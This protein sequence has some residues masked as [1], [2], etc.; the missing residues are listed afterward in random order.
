[1]ALRFAI[2]VTSKRGAKG[3]ARPGAVPGKRNR[4]SPEPWAQDD[5][6]REICR[7]KRSIRSSEA[8]HRRWHTEVGRVGNYLQDSKLHS[9]SRGTLRY[10]SG[11]HVDGD[12]VM[13]IR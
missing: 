11:F 9:A 3:A 4:P 12:G 13:T 7:A 1:M 6:T 2:Q 8:I 10:G 5:V